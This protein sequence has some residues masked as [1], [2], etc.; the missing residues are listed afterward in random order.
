MSYGAYR[1]NRAD[2][3]VAA[4]HK[5][6]AHFYVAFTV[7]LRSNARIERRIILQLPHGRLDR[8]DGF[9]ACGGQAPPCARWPAAASTA[10]ATA[11]ASRH[12]TRLAARSSSFIVFAPP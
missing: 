7:G 12:P 5:R 3:E 9:A 8:I 1:T 10:L 11:K 4:F 6:G 2:I